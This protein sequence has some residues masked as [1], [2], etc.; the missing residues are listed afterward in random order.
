[1]S[2]LTWDVLVLAE[3]CLL[4]AWD[5]LPVD[6]RPGRIGIVPGRDVVADDCCEGIAWVRRIRTFRTDVETFPSALLRQQAPCTDWVWGVEFGVGV[7]RCAPTVDDSGNAPTVADL[8]AAA[9]EIADDEERVRRALL[10]CLP[11]ALASY[12]R[13]RSSIGVLMSLGDAVS[14]GPEG[15]CHAFEM[16]M[17]VGLPNCICPP[18]G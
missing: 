11:T 15:G 17:I 9:L 8:R 14:I 12:V 10:C 4:A 1:M 2:G 6:E 3:T 16:T 18:N 7:L 5:D 13:R